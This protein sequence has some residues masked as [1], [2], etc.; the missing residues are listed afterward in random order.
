MASRFPLSPQPRLTAAYIGDEREPV[1][2]AEAMLDQPQTLV[3]LAAPGSFAPAFSSA[4]GYP[5]LRAPAPRDYVETI[6][7]ALTGPIGEAFALGPIRPVEANCS[8][9]L[10]TLPEDQLVPVQRAPHVD[11]VDGWQFAILHYLCDAGF[12]GTAFYRHRATGYETLTEDRLPA[13]HAARAAEGWAAGY[14]EDGAP[15]FD[16]IAEVS[17]HFNSLVVYRSRVLHSG[18]ILAPERLSPDPRRGRLTAN[19]FVT[20]AAGA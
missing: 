20:F 11:T 7:R 12:G 5:G 8:Y 1:L 2:R 6:V 19:I 9:S 17:A 13:Y 10:V 14:V 4:G 16:K 3:D 18:R 15:W